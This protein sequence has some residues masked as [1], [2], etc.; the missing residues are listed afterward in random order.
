[1]QGKM[2]LSQSQE[3]LDMHKYPTRLLLSR[4]AETLKFSKCLGG[5]SC[6]NEK[7]AGKIFG[8]CEPM[9]RNPAFLEWAS[10]SLEGF[11]GHAWHGGWST[12]TGKGECPVIQPP[13]PSCQPMPMFG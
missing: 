13:P 7:L 3:L 12:G 5:C 10:P 1:M 6:S 2:K 9:L 4:F 11:G 8:C